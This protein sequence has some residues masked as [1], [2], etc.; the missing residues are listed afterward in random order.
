MT[1]VLNDTVRFGLVP[2]I[3]R[4]LLVSEFLVALNGKITGWDGQAAYMASKG[5]LNS[6]TTALAKS[7][8]PN[9][10]VNAVLPGMVD[11]RWLR[12]GLGPERYAAAQRNYESNST[13]AALVRPEEV[14]EA[15]FYLAAVATKTT[16][17]FQLVDGGRY[18]GR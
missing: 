6:M 4:L 1:K 18:L 15:V 11:S 9:I 7:L 5:A 12:N 16:G 2:L 10:R 8:G 14:A 13:L 17:E 3:A